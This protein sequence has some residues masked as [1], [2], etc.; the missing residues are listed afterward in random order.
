MRPTGASTK[1][2][3]RV[4]PHS[5]RS[6]EEEEPRGSDF[7]EREMSSV[8]LRIGHLTHRTDRRNRTAMDVLTA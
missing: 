2:R 8:S 3:E 6:P 4:Q 5:P 1:D 7:F